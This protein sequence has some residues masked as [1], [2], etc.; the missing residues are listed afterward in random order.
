MVMYNSVLARYVSAD[1]KHAKEIAVTTMHSWL[2]GFFKEL[3]LGR[4][5]QRE[6]WVIDW[7]AV[8]GALKTSMSR[9]RASWGHLVV[10]EGQDFPQ[11]MYVSLALLLAG[12]RGPSPAPALSVFA[13]ENQRITAT[14]ST[15]PQLRQAL[16]LVG[17]DRVFELTTN[18]R[19]TTEVARFAA[20]FYCGLRTGIPSPPERKGQKPVVSFH[21]NQ[22]DMIESIIEL[23]EEARDRE[24]SVGIICPR[25]K[26]RRYL[27]RR[28]EERYGGDGELLIQS[29]SS[30]DDSLHAKD[31][32]FDDPDRVTVLSRPSVKGLEFDAV[33]IV[34]PFLSADAE[35]GSEQQ[36]KMNMYV[37]CSRAR[38]FLRLCF[39]SDR[40]KVERVLPRKSDG[41][42]DVLGEGT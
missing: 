20:H 17:A 3:G 31:L 10:D 9:G 30:K 35:G 36:F 33:V 19:N 11:E 22:P 40:A 29:Y 18:Y 26:T 13:D 32:V 5:P 12:Y 27:V 4:V 25:D 37:S 38:E 41:L 15:I 23:V 21:R 34:D 7:P 6:R 42:F 14:N 39:V 24:W 28:L 16:A 2:G 8:A 1:N